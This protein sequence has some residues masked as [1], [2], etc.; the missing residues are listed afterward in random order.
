MSIR[1]GLALALA[2]AGI[3]VALA[4][5]AAV[6]STDYSETPTAY[7]GRKGDA[8]QPHW[9]TPCRRRDRTG[10]RYVLKCGRVRGVIVFHESRDSD[11]D[12]DVHGIA[13]AGAKLVVLKSRRGREG[14]IAIPGVGRRVGAAGEVLKGR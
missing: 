3:A 13:V 10:R 11:G 14:A 4:A 2:V 7:Y 12:G 9:S 1:R 5:L 6:S 8:P